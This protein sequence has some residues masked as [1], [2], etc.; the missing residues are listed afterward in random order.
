MPLATIRLYSV[1]IDCLAVGLLDLAAAHF[2]HM[3][4][5]GMPAV[6]NLFFVVP[7]L[8]QKQQIDFRASRLPQTTLY[9]IIKLESKSSLVV[10]INI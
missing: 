2:V 10:N 1:L 6:S 8:S 7:T 4:T 5:V 3:Y 9:F